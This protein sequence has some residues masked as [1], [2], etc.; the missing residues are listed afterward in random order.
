M[1]AE[2]SLGRPLI[3]TGRG[4]HV[5][6]VVAAQDGEDV[7]APTRVSSPRSASTRRCPPWA[8]T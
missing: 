8:S 6:E 2:T 1:E 5:R 7:P 4:D 3:I